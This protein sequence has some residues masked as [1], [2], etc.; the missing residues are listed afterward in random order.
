MLQCHHT[1]ANDPGI[2]HY[3]APWVETWISVYRIGCEYPAS[4][5]P[6]YVFCVSLPLSLSSYVYFSLSQT[7]SLPFPGCVLCG[8]DSLLSGGGDV[9]QR[10]DDVCLHPAATD[11]S[12]YITA[13]RRT[14]TGTVFVRVCLSVGLVQ[15]Q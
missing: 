1:N 9:R 8:P 5:L 10:E 11:P 14:Q 6:V 4:T 15:P 13:R 7:F 3:K 12:Q 2:I